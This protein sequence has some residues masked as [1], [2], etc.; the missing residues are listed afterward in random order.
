[1]SARRTKAS[2]RAAFRRA[3]TIPVPPIVCHFDAR[4]FLR[5]SRALARAFE[6]AA[7]AFLAMLRTVVAGEAFDA[8]QL[9]ALRPDG[10]AYRAV[11]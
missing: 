2:R 9:V 7:R 5:A 11:R 1:M 8:G 10:R 4:P 3:N 6:R